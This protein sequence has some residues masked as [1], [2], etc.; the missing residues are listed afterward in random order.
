MNLKVCLLSA[1]ALAALFVGCNPDKIE[2]TIP[3]Y[4]YIDSFSINYPTPAESGRGAQKVTEAWIYVNDELHSVTPLP[5]TVPIP[6]VGTNQRISIGPGIRQNGIAATRVEYPFYERYEVIIPEVEPDSTYHLLP[7]TQYT[8]ATLFPYMEDFESSVVQLDSISSSDV[9]IYKESMG[10]DTEP[11]GRFV[12]KAVLTADKPDLK[13][14]SS[15]LYALPKG[16]A[17]VYL[18][19]DYKCNA[20]FIVGVIYQL[21]QQ[22]PV[23]YPVVWVQPTNRETGTPEWNKMYIEL[24]PHVS[25]NLTAL[26]FGFTLTASHE[27]ANSES[28]LYFD[29][30]KI[31]H[32]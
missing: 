3:G 19:L 18:E 15:E 16:G 26:G 22:N 21:P 25:S 11:Y 17:P 4:V 5:G 23:D 24:T 1:F 8:D 2:A 13:L 30:L 27:P 9:N 20:Q 28:V 29:N 7:V 6:Q 12:G 32:R 31:V 10:Q 14:A